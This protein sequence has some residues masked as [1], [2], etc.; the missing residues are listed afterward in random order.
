[1]YPDI[2]PDRCVI[3][4]SQL[5]PGATVARCAREDHDGRECRTV[6][7]GLYDDRT[8]HAGGTEETGST[9]G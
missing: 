3:L 1:M 6:G 9:G 4:T 2:T 7:I 8:P 5:V